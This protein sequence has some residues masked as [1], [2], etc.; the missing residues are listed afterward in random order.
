MLFPEEDAPVLKDWIVKRLEN[1]F[2]A[3]Y[4]ITPLSLYCFLC[5]TNDS[6]LFV[7]PMPTLMSLPITC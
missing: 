1:T 2:V 7:D 3:L 6:N 5:V 4:P